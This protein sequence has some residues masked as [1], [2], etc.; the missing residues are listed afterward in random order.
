MHSQ[1]AGVKTIED[2]SRSA[3][4]VLSQRVALSPKKNIEQHWLAGWKKRLHTYVR[5]AKKSD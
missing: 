1:A 2:F 5:E 3:A 4:A